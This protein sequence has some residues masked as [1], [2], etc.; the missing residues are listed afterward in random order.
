MER[1]KFDQIDLTDIDVKNIKH[2]RG[3]EYVVS[4]IKTIKGIRLN[5]LYYGG[6]G[7]HG[8]T[9]FIFKKKYKYNDHYK[10]YNDVPAIEAKGI[11]IYHE[12]E[13][14]R[15]VEDF[16]DE[17][18]EGWLTSINDPDEQWFIED[19]KLVRG[20]ISFEMIKSIF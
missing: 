15:F 11:F 14:E 12:G 13:I 18:N 17:Y 6:D 16:I 1:N 8:K 19:L 20:K 4:D 3:E 5:V 9:Y 10:H 7:V 2:K